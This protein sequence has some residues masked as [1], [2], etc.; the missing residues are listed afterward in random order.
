MTSAE[1]TEFLTRLRAYGKAL[2]G[3]GFGHIGT[4]KAAVK[5]TCV[6]LEEVAQLIESMPE[7]ELVIEECVDRV[8]PR[9]F[10]LREHNLSSCECQTVFDRIKQ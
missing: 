3:D 5:R 6:R 8:N 1:I 7:G 2:E 10:G 9:C 4:L